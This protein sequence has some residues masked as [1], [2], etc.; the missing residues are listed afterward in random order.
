[1]DL[2]DFRPQRRVHAGGDDEHG[3][4]AGIGLG[5]AQ[6]LEHRP[7]SAR[8]VALEQL[9]DAFG[10]HLVQVVVEAQHQRGV[11]TDRRRLA[12]GE[13]H[14]RDARHRDGNRQEEQTEDE[15]HTTL[16]HSRALP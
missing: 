16:C 10:G 14:D 8:P 15:P 1:M 2:L 6:V 13:V 9:R 7:Q 3:L 4:D 5:L 12:D 11:A